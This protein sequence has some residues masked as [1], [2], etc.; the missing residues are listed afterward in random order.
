M[1]EGLAFSDGRVVL[2]SLGI[3]RTR[4]KHVLDIHEAATENSASLRR[5]A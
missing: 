1:I 2:I 4:Q 3:D 5:A